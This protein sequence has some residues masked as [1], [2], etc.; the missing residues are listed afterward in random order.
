VSSLTDAG[1]AF[2][3]FAQAETAEDQAALVAPHLFGGQNELLL[4][5][6]SGAT[7][8]ALLGYSNGDHTAE[9][10]SFADDACDPLVAIGGSSLTSLSFS[11]CGYDFSLPDTSGLTALTSLGFSRCG[12][13]SSFSLSDTSGLTALTSLWFT[14]CGYG[15]G[16]NIT[17]TVTTLPEAKALVLMTA[18]DT[19]ISVGNGTDD[20]LNIKVSGTSTLQ[21][22]KTALE[23]KGWTVTLAT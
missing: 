6:G 2:P 9:F 23:A 11:Y 14:Y 4:L 17:D 21:A 20:V 19:G 16:V 8:G 7:K 18:L 3:A 15:G 10:S 12:Y 1:A 5:A 13:S 22:K